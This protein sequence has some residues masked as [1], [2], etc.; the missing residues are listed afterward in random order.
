MMTTATLVRT[1]EVIF[2]ILG[3]SAIFSSTLRVRSSSIF[4]ALAPGQ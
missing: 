4:S 1:L 3:F 2:S